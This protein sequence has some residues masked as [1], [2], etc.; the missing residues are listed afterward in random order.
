M[1]L[2]NLPYPLNEQVDTS[3]IKGIANHLPENTFRYNMDKKEHI[4]SILGDVSQYIVDRSE[5]V[6][7]DPNALE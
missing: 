7:N 1:K 3:S 5:I 2:I 6:E 4:E